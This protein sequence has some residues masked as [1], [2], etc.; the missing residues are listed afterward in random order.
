MPSLT[1]IA[2]LSLALLLTFWMECTALWAATPYYISASGGNDAN[3]GLTP[4][5]AWKSIEKVNSSIFQPGDSILFNRGD[6]WREEL[7]ITWSGTSEAYI[8]FG[9]Y[10]SGAKPRILGS[11]QATNWTL[12]DG[13]TN[14]WRSGT[15]L[16]SP[17]IGKPA[18]IFFGEKDG[19]TTW[20]RVLSDSS[21]PSCGNGYSTLQQEHDWCYSNAIY[22]YAPSPPSTRYAFVEVPQRRGSITMESHNVQE[23]ICIDGLELM[24]GT[25]Y[26]YNDGWPMNYER[27]GLI[28]KNCH[29]GYIGIR[30]GASAMGLA[31]WHSNMLVQNNEIHD[32]GRRSISYNIYTD[33]SAQPNGLVFANVVFENNTLHHGYHTTGFDVSHG[34]ARVNILRDFTF[35]NNFIYDVNSD[36]PNG[37]IDDYTS[38][39]LYLWTGAAD[40]VDFKIYNNVFK[41]I[42]QK[43]LAIGSGS[44]MHRNLAIY[45]NVLYGMNPNISGYR[46]QAHIGG[47][48]QNLRFNNNI[49]YGTIDPNAFVSRCLYVSEDQSGVA[50][51]DNNLYFQDY[52]NQQIIE[53]FSGSYTI[54]TWKNYQIA[55]GW[56]KNS[57]DP[58][59]IPDPEPS[60]RKPQNP[61]FVDPNSNDFRLRPGSSALSAGIDVGLPFTGQAPDIGIQSSIGRIGAIP[62]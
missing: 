43:G 10:G 15:Q 48:H 34:D 13:Q 38:M 14:V 23:Y 25:M 62:R 46:A 12:V 31:I 40:F 51:L 36:N 56:D 42:K 27:H 33:N 24:Y 58:G 21:V 53:A 6:V 29:I 19:T 1:K 55:T 49:M 3:N 28:I 16:A 32:C 44:G 11:E 20:G 47:N 60:P 17:N 30:G 35:R 2:T 18:S 5:T 45:N 39:G 50:S 37:R 7:V 26:G 54:S 59:Q 57:P 8:T 61:W 4:E 9:T 52:P 41:N 22:I